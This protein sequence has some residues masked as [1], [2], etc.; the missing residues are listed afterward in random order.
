MTSFAQTCK[1]RFCFDHGAETAIYE[2]TL[3]GPLSD[4]V[5]LPV[6]IEKVASR[7]RVPLRRLAVTLRRWAK[8]QP[9]VLRMALNCS[10][11]RYCLAV[12]LAAPNDER[13]AEVREQLS[14]ALELLPS[15]ASC[16][17]ILSP[18]QE[19]S[20]LF[21]SADTYTIHVNYA[22]LQ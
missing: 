16:L 13:L 4:A 19:D 17:Y 22:A 8:T 6:E 11:K 15:L 2:S 1:I 5:L 3:P 9:D 7:D 14:E 18:E 20:L 21:R 12:M 10:G